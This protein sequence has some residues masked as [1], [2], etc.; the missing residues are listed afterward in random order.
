MFLGSYPAAG[1]AGPAIRREVESS[2]RQAGAWL[3]GL[4]AE[5]G[6]GGIR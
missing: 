5:I 2:M 6:P 1:P 4:T 3:D